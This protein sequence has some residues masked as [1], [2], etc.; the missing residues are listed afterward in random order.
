MF[1]KKR[2]S[3]K[4]TK[5]KDRIFRGIKYRTVF[6]IYDIRTI[7]KC[8]GQLII[9]IIIQFTDKQKKKMTII[10]GERCIIKNNS[11]ILI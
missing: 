7:Y 3:I 2:N 10:L 8:T 9:K 1:I 5:E 11:F 4:K 6:T